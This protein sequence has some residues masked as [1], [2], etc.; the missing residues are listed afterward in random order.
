MDVGR[1]GA[2]FA[3]E[4]GS[5]LVVAHAVPRSTINLGGVYFDPRWHEQVRTEAE[6]LIGF[7]LSEIGAKAEIIVKTGDTP[8]AV[9]TVAEECGANVLV[10]GRGH[11]AGTLGRLRTNA[12]AILRE[13]PCPV[14]AI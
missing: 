10:I 11:A 2:A 4:Y 7:L 13:S 6:G 3:R 9:S 1:G 5:K 12:Y 8:H 14:A